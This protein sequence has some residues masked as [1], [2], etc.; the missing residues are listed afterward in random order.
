MNQEKVRSLRRQINE[1]DA[2]AGLC[3]QWAAGCIQELDELVAG[4]AE[5]ETVYT[6]AYEEQKSRADDLDTQV[7]VRNVEIAKLEQALNN[8]ETEDNIVM[9]AYKARE[10]RI[11]ELEQQVSEL[12]AQL[13]PAQKPEPPKRES[14]WYSL[15]NSRWYFNVA[16]CRF[17][18]AYCRKWTDASYH[19]I[20]SMT[21]CD[22]PEYPVGQLMECVETKTRLL[23]DDH[24][25]AKDF[26]DGVERYILNAGP[27]FA[28]YALPAVDVT[29]P[30]KW[31]PVEDA[32]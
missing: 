14:G 5:R 17:W 28:L 3:K 31:I 19:S 6:R 25:P 20:C 13:P 30:T 4:A 7:G 12:S 24:I 27:G 1:L 2:A 22:P 26:D 21:P 18:S 16:T 8:I 23:I 10:S 15:N 9:R 29:N 32:E 11:E